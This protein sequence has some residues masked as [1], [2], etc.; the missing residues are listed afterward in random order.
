[1]EIQP[2]EFVCRVSPSDVYSGETVTAYGWTQHFNPYL[3]ISYAWCATGGH[4]DSIDAVAQF[5]TTGL[6]PG[7]YTI[8]GHAEQG[9]EPG[10]GADCVGRFRISER[11]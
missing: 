7:E 8:T 11:L 6:E 5:D 3:H 2:L 9:S 10:Q 4:T 1:M